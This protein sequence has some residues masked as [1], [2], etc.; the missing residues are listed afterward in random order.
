MAKSVLKQAKRKRSAPYYVNMVILSLITLIML[1]PFYDVIILSFANVG[2]LGRAK[3]Y[4]LPISF[5]L[6]P[7]KVLFSSNAIFKGFLVTALVVVL[8]TAFC[9]LIT[10]SAAYSLSK[11][12]LPFRRTFM[13]LIIIT[14]F[15]G[16]GLIPYYLTIKSLGMINNLLVLI[17]PAG[18]NTMYLI[19]VKNYFQTIPASLEESAKVDGAN[20]IFILLRIII[21]ISMPM[22]A[23]FIL[24]YA[25]DRWNDWWYAF[26][27]ISSPSLRPLQ[28]VLKDA[29]S[30]LDNITSPIGRTMAQKNNAYNAQSVRMAMVVITTVPILVVY[31]FLQKYFTK[32]IML[33]S[34]KG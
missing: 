29:L 22:M 4:L 15:F 23:T 17:V 18:I 32:G 14:M 31:P 27:F 8:G 30:N 16:G 26:I 33:G 24:F 3:V 9:M 28:I 1:L 7:Y 19:I 2:A 5:D 10:V 6:T 12:T 25:V 11:K 34:I 21:P 13:I 20:D